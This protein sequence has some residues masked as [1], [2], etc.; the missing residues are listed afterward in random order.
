M[1]RDCGRGSDEC[2]VTAVGVEGAGHCGAGVG[3]GSG[4]GITVVRTSGCRPARD[5]PGSRKSNVVC[6]GCARLG[7]GVEQALLRIPTAEVAADCGFCEEMADWGS[8]GRVGAA[9]HDAAP[10]AGGSWACSACVYCPAGGCGDDD[11]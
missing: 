11:V 5:I 1:I 3:G 6:G 9:R 8:A 10:R 7:G 4:G 2:G